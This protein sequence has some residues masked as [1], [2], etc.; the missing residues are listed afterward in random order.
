MVFIPTIDFADYDESDDAV[1]QRLSDEVS[2]ALTRRGTALP[3][4]YCRRHI[5]EKI[6]ASHQAAAKQ[7]Q[8]E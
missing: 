3:R 8:I 5:Q 6:Q 4:G 2:H 7:A 1:M